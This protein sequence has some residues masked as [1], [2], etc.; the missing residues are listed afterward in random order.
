M[1]KIGESYDWRGPYEGFWALEMFYFF[2]LDVKYTS[3]YVIKLCVYMIYF[4]IK[5]TNKINNIRKEYMEGS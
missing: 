2:Y 4:S 3:F 1:L 5:K